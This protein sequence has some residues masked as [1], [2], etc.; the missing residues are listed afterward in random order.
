MIRAPLAIL[1][2]LTGLILL[3]YLDRN[4]VAAVLPNVLRDLSLT[5]TE[6]GFLYTAFLLG[7][8]LTG[9]FFA[10]FAFFR[11]TRLVLPVEIIFP[12][13]EIATSPS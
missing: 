11:A 4:I 8:S 2:I 6:G 10:F 9:P 13:S 12:F 7:Y 3:N 1:F 5:K